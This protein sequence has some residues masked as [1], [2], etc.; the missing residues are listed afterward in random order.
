VNLGGQ[1]GQTRKTGQARVS[2]GASGI[3]WQAKTGLNCLCSLESRRGFHG[4]GSRTNAAETAENPLPGVSSLAWKRSGFDSPQVHQRDS[5]NALR[6][7]FLRVVSRTRA[8]AV[9][10]YVASSRHDHFHPREVVREPIAFRSTGRLREY[11]PR[12]VCK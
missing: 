11:E 3:A 6:G 1:R 10:D 9:K 2:C 4:S 12:Q 8:Q 5:M 7:V